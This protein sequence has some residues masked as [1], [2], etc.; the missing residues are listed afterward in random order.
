[1]V[2]GWNSK[3]VGKYLEGKQDGEWIFDKEVITPN[4]ILKMESNNPKLPSRLVISFTVQVLTI[5][6]HE[7]HFLNKSFP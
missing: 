4:L 1:M 6:L 3:L 5:S 7:Q 2:S